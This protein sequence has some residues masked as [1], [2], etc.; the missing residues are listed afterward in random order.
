MEEFYKD[1]EYDIRIYKTKD[2]ES[3]KQ[4]ITGNSKL[5]I[6]TGISSFLQSCL[7]SNFMTPDELQEIVNMVFKVRKKGA[8]NKVVYNSFER[9][10]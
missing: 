7:D 4:I 3:S 10:D 2:M 6:I 5:G 8:R 9:N 1:Y